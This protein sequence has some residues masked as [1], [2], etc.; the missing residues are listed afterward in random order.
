[1]NTRGKRAEDNEDELARTRR[2]VQAISEQSKVG[3]MFMLVTDD[4]IE[5][6]GGV[7]QLL[8]NLESLMKKLRNAPVER[9][10]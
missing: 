6:F 3:A 2:R 8:S 9:V 7:E 4:V 10:Q 5:S 1:M